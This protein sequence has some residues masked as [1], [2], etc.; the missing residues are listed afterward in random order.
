MA[1]TFEVLTV[2]VTC[3]VQPDS[4]VLSFAIRSSPAFLTVLIRIVFDCS[5]AGWITAIESFLSWSCETITSVVGTATTV[6]TV[7][8]VSVMIRSLTQVVRSVNIGMNLLEE[9]RPL[10]G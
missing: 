1:E 5:S 8:A 7:T 3:V 6:T 9:T 10:S 2:C 4:A